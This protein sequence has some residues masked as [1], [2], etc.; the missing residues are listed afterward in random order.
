M[1][2]VNQKISKWE[3]SQ[4]IKL[5]Q[6]KTITQEKFGEAKLYKGEIRIPKNIKMR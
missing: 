5:K 1:K 3:N 2:Y 6:L 4:S